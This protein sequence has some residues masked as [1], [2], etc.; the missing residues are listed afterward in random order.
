[1]TLVRLYKIESIGSFV[2]SSD[3]T[4]FAYLAE[5]KKANKDKSFFLV[6]YKKVNDEKVKTTYEGVTRQNHYKF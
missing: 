2:W 3:S 1:M 6:D 4:K 5:A